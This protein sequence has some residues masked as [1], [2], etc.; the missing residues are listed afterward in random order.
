M[1][2]GS[3]APEKS[4]DCVCS[5][6]PIGNDVEDD[7]AYSVMRTNDAGGPLLDERANVTSDNWYVPG[8][9]CGSDSGKYSDT[10]RYIL[11]EIVRIAEPLIPFPRPFVLSMTIC[12]GK[13][14]A[15]AVSVT[16]GVCDA[17]REYD[18]V[19]LAVRVSVGVTE[20]VEDTVGDTLGVTDCVRVRDGVWDCVCDGDMLCE[21]VRAPDMLWD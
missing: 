17:V 4:M 7:A 3:A 21:G 19:T 5:A 12:R 8:P 9:H 2:P 20:S 6:W 11:L 10:A 13:P 14:V 16:L 15:L 1:Y 18:G